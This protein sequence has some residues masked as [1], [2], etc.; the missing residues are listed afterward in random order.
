MTGYGCACLFG[1]TGAQAGRRYHNRLD[2]IST[3]WNV[4]ADFFN[5]IRRFAID[6]GAPAAW[7][8]SCCLFS[9]APNDGRS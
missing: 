6:R 5:Q 2:V 9:E 3:P 8:A 4:L 7:H 1:G